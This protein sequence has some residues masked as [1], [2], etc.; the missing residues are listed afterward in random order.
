MNSA[1]R[2]CAIILTLSG[3]LAGIAMMSPARVQ[4]ATLHVVTAGTLTVTPNPV[5]VGTTA[6]VQ[7]TGF[8]PNSTALVFWRR[9]D[10]T[11]NAIL[12]G[13][14]GSGMFSFVLGFAPRHGIGTELVAALD[15]ATQVRTPTVAVTVLAR[16]AGTGMLSASV[17]P[18]PNGG[19][20]VIMGTGF[21]PGALVVVQW[22]RP[23]GTTGAVHIFA[24][25]AGTFAF[26]LLAD[27]RHGCGSRMF[28]A[29]DTTTLLA[30]APFSLGEIC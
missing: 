1:I 8:T 13:T 27:P 2:P 19:V 23:D 6:A 11:R 22:H 14:N 29:L 24:N 4:G 15:E 26:Q 21:T 5:M 10:N 30:A 18:V 20:T 9:P 28:T 17:N 25:M 12:I 7:G 3:V 16:G